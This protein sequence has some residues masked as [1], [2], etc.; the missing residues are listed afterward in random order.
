MRIT[1]CDRCGLLTHERKRASGEI[2]CDHCHD[3]KRP[4]PSHAAD[5]QTMAA[6]AVPSPERV[7]RTIQRNLKK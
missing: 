3:G 1:F 4:A 2:L 6:V 7:L 5:S